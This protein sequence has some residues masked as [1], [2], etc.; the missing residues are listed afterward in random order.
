MSRS[1]IVAAVRTPFGTL[2]GGLASH[3]GTELGAFAIRA[4]LDRAGI[5]PGEPQYV[6]MGQ[7]LQGGSGQAP[8]R[9]AAVGA[10]L[11]KATPSDTINKVCASSIRTVEIADSLIRVGD[12]EALGTG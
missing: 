10:G 4:A 8:A 7:V 5:E 11:P 2:G 3:S 12:I 1:V 9:Q 6:M